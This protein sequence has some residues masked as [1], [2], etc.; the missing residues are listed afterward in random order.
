[1]KRA[2]IYLMIL[3]V[4]IVSLSCKLDPKLK[5][6]DIIE[7]SILGKVYKQAPHDVAVVE[8]PH[9]VKRIADGAFGN[10]VWLKEVTIPDTV[11]G[12]GS[13]AFFGCSGLTSIT[14]PNSVT[15]IGSDA[16]KDCTCSIVFASGMT[17]IPSGALSGADG[18]P[19]VTIPKTVISI[20]SEAFKGCSKLANL[21]FE[22]TVAQWGDVSKGLGWGAGV[23]TSVIH[24][25]DGDVNK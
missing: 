23:P 11:T 6:A 8:I 25:S 10:A 15:E 1:M 21:R 13:E 12:I 22:G 4:I 5:E 3:V 17:T 7:D 16:F 18:I 24:C 2:L 9:G 14:I 19:S 20:G